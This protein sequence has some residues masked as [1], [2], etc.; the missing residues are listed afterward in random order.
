[1]STDPKTRNRATP[2]RAHASDSALVSIVTLTATE[3]FSQNRGTM[4]RDSSTP[5]AETA[6]SPNAVGPAGQGLPHGAQVAV[7]AGE[8]LAGL[9][10]LEPGPERGRTQQ[11]PLLVV[12]LHD[13]HTAGTQQ[14]DRAHK[15]VDRDV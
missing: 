10:V 5:A 15:D 13:E 12:V 2:N 8:V 6:S 9:R 1:M 14:G 4:T 7:A 11:R 3:L